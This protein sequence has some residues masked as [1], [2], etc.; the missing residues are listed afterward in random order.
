MPEQFDE[1][2]DIGVH[3]PSLEHMRVKLWSGLREHEYCAVLWNVIF[4][5]EG[6]ISVA[7]SIWG[8]LSQSKTE[9]E[10]NLCFAVL[11]NAISTDYSILQLY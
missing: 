6:A 8:G 11:C 3:L 7:P 10:F 2:F 9:T 1:L 5:F 4:V